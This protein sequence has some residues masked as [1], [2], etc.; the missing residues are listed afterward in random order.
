[1][2]PVVAI[3]IFLLDV[4]WFTGCR[5]WYG[6][7]ENSQGDAAILV[8]GLVTLRFAGA[9]IF[10]EQ[11]NGWKYHLGVLAAS[12]FLVQ[13][14]FGVAKLWLPPDLRIHP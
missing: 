14:I 5:C 4:G 8:I 7:W 10:A 6:A 3:P 11:N 12:P 1:M 2:L 9:W 13:G